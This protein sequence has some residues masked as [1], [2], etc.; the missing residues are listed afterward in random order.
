VKSKKKKKNK[1]TIKLNENFLKLHIIYPD[2]Q[3]FSNYSR[4]NANEYL[5]LVKRA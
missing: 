3:F 1:K 4:R 2:I 5:S